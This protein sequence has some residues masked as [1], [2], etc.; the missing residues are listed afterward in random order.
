[1]QIFRALLLALVIV[2]TF[3]SEAGAQS[4]YGRRLVGRNGLALPV[5]SRLLSSDAHM[6]VGRGS[7]LAWDLN[8]PL[9]SPIFPIAPGT[10]IYSGCN[11]AG[12][13]GCWTLISHGDGLKSIMGHMIAGSI[14]VQAGDRVGLNTVVGRVGWTGMTSFGPHVHLE[15]HHAAASGGRIDPAAIWN[16]NQMIRC[17]KCSSGNGA[18]VAPSG[19]TQLAGS[20]SPDGSPNA[21]WWF[22]AGVAATVAVAQMFVSPNGWLAFSLWHGAAWAMPILVVA[23]MPLLMTGEPVGGWRNAYQV[24]VASE[25]GQCTRDPVHTKGGITQGAYDAWRMARGLGY[26]DVCESLTE[27]ERQAIF[28]GR[29][30]HASGADRL[31]ARLAL[32]YVD[33]AFNAGVGAAQGALTRCGYDVRC[34]NNTREMYYRSAASFP[35]Y[36]AGWLNRL[37]RIRELTEVY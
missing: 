24:V 9:G 18:P 36:G 37:D 28:V 30:W 20:R 11:N 25:G 21:L 23:A 29:Y 6:H 14:L 10:V 12:G 26:A 13:Y 35:I 34:F 7:V 15:V 5:A 32:T 33:F 8:A 17:D 4:P 1:M 16:I 19:F 31:P 2:T 27:G 3:S 22:L